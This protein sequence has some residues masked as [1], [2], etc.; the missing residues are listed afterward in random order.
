MECETKSSICLC[1]TAKI[2]SQ[3]SIAFGVVGDGDGESDF[4]LSPFWSIILHAVQIGLHNILKR[5]L[6]QKK[7]A[8]KILISSTYD[9][10]LKHFPT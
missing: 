4:N 1:F 6:L 7:L 8:H 5:C 10:Y 2:I 9:L 3:I